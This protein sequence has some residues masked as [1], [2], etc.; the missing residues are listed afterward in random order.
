MRLNPI[1]SQPSVGDLPPCPLK[2]SSLTSEV[3]LFNYFWSAVF[4]LSFL[5]KLAVANSGTFHIEVIFLDEEGSEFD[6][7]NSIEVKINVLESVGSRKAS[8]L[9]ENILPKVRTDWLI[10]IDYIQ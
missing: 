1:I 10:L 5:L 4:I 9:V 2:N 3:S 8:N 7:T 6:R